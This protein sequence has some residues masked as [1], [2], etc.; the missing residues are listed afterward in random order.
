[1]ISEL[2]PFPELFLFSRFLNAVHVSGGKDQI[3]RG[4][5]F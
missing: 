4:G 3:L 1:M 5:L 2:P